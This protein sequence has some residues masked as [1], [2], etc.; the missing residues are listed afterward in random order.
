[1]FF[2]S[3]SQNSHFCKSLYT[4]IPIRISE[5]AISS[6]QRT[7]HHP[8]QSCGLD[9]KSESQLI[10]HIHLSNFRKNVAVKRSKFIDSNVA[11]LSG[12]QNWWENDS[13]SARAR[14]LRATTFHSFQPSTCRNEDTCHVITATTDVE[15]NTTIWHF[16]VFGPSRCISGR[17][18]RLFS[19]PSM[20][21]KLKSMKFT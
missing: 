7:V 13:Q 17:K 8:W 9:F 5:A 1:M 20:K 21:S 19:L 3:F 4:H 6:H 14:G 15:Q 16:T 10:D 18:C 12:C 11:F 2:F